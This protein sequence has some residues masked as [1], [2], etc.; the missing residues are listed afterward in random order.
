MLL[1]R[2]ALD[3]FFRKKK[4]ILYIISIAFTIGII[5][6]VLF[7]RY[8]IDVTYRNTLVNS[9]SNR[10]LAAFYSRESESGKDEALKELASY[11]Y[12]TAIYPAVTPIPARV[13]DKYECFIAAGCDQELPIVRYGSSVMLDN[14]NSVKVILPEY[15]KTE[16]AL[17]ETKN[18][19]NHTVSISY[20]GLNVGGEVAGIYYNQML[21]NKIYISLKDMEVFTEY[22]NDLIDPKS[23][24]I[25][26]DKYSYVQ[27]TMGYLTRHSFS[28]NIYDTSGLSQ[29]E[30]Y[31]TLSKV[32]IASVYAMAFFIFILLRRVISNM[33]QDE[34]RDFALLKALG[35]SNRQLFQ[36]V[37]IM[38]SALMALSYIAATILSIPIN[39]IIAYA[40]KEKSISLIYNISVQ[41]RCSAIPIVF[42]TLI[43]II[44]AFINKVKL[45]N[46]D[47]IV[48][49]KNS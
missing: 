39:T 32:L 33:L 16:N 41:L 10:K 48:L 8:S 18:L 43:S 28:S 20:K 29:L 1:F 23:Y 22:D 14:D 26:V 9:I 21:E 46:I 25:V 27:R 45:E 31:N 7:I 49:L 37:L 34:Q 11:D 30:L 24:F 4:I 13:D 5:I 17:I 3:S 35:Y 38:V 2:P 47:P 44:S 40:A 36:V 6:S 15:M 12:I 19:L 42:I